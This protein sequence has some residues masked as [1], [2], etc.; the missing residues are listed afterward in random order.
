MMYDMVVPTKE[1][2]KT[3]N[4]RIDTANAEPRLKRDPTVNGKD[5]QAS[6]EDIDNQKNKSDAEDLAKDTA[7]AIDNVNKGHTGNNVVDT[8]INAK[9]NKYKMMYDMVV[10]TK[11][12]NK[13]ENRRLDTANESSSSPDRLKK[14][15]MHAAIAISNR[16]RA[17]LENR[18]DYLMHYGRKGMKWGEDVFAEDELNKR[19][20]GSQSQYVQQLKAEAYKRKHGNTSVTTNDDAARANG[21]AIRA[22]QKAI[23]EAQAK[24]GGGSNSNYANQQ[25]AKQ[26]EESRRAAQN[27]A[28]SEKYGNK[29]GSV[30]QGSSYVNGQL[31]NQQKKTAKNME[32]ASSIERTTDRYIDDYMSRNKNAQLYKSMAV[33]TAMNDAERLGNAELSNIMSGKN[34]LASK[35][36]NA[37]DNLENTM[38]NEIKK[39]IHDDIDAHSDGLTPAQIAQMKGKADIAIDKKFDQIH[40]RYSSNGLALTNENV[41]STLEKGAEELG[42]NYAMSTGG[43]HD[44]SEYKPLLTV[45]DDA[46]ETAGV[47]GEEVASKTEAPAPKTEAPAP[48]TEAPAPK[49]EGAPKKMTAKQNHI[50]SNG[51]RDHGSFTNNNIDITAESIYDAGNSRNVQKIEEMQGLI[52][53]RYKDV[54][55]LQQNPRFNNKYGSKIQQELDNL[56]HDYGWLER[57]KRLA[58]RY[59][60]D[61]AFID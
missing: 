5:E 47:K 58:A 4:R 51:L 14:K 42:R 21:A 26:A 3:E 61:Y 55:N 7:Q 2:N 57:R 54:L 50:Q 11:E 56:M 46:V 53:D 22:R 49:A 29:Y 41:K 48:K 45:D 16:R 20:S 36:R 44:V 18:D 43:L 39:N 1:T 13:T 10:P 27:K 30:G 32:Y 24:Y 35:Q 31:S 12:T 38:K 8:L 34:E 17:Q 9:T 15:I 33:D 60:E 6:T 23:R 19:Q 28:A 40:T 59:A 52:E 37:R 25:M